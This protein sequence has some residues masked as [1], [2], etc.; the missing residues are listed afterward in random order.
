[1]FEVYLKDSGKIFVKND[2][3]V[4]R[5]PIKFHIRESEKPLYESLIRASSILNYEI[6]PSEGE[7]KVKKPG[8]LSK[9]KPRSDI[10]FNLKIQG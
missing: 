2:G 7:V 4:V 8:R 3:K 5:T 9:I 6:N 1:M 10:N